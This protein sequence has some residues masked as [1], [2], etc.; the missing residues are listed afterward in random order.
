M[1]KPKEKFTFFYRSESPFSQWY[2]AVFVVGEYTFDSAEQYM[3]YGKAMLFGDKEIADKIR[4]AK[5]PRQQKQLG[6]QVQH[7]DK[8]VWDEHARQIVYEGNHAK[9]TQN[10]ELLEAL[11]ATK[12]TTL[13]EAS[14]T[15]RIWGIGLAEEDP[16]VHN[17]STWR[18]TNWLG[19]VLTE[20]REQL[21]SDHQK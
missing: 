11:L 16:R 5:H 7:F 8:K 2:P 3:M 19:E 12:G 15:D 4:S 1:S 18:G 6:R 17:R 20:L 13:V 21:L 10:K 14:P 9:F